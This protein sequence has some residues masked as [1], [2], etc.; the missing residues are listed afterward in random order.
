MCLVCLV[1]CPH[2]RRLC[3]VDLGGRACCSAC[4]TVLLIDVRVL[5]P[6]RP[7]PKARAA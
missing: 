3:H 5:P 2:C 1:Q 4:G 7:Q 6:T